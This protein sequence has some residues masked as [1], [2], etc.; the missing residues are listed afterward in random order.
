MEM[1]SVTFKDY[2]TAF[3]PKRNMPEGVTREYV[4]LS[5]IVLTPYGAGKILVFHSAK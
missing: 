5:R 3:V 1:K 2:I 4:V